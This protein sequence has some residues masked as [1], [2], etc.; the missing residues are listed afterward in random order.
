MSPA[1]TASLPRDSGV[2]T[3]KAPLTQTS[4]S[5]RSAENYRSQIAIRITNNKRH[6]HQRQSRYVSHFV[7]LC[8]RRI[9]GGKVWRGSSSTAPPHH[10]SLLQQFYFI[11]Q[12]RRTICLHVEMLTCFCLNPPSIHCVYVCVCVCLCVYM[13][14]CLM[15]CSIS[16]ASCFGGL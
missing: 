13:C 8:R 7:S 12:S 15:N 11:P 14:V 9:A 4:V 1:G 10:N 2:V 5:G 6:K 16:L 3:V